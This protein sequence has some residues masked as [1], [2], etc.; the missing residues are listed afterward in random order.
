MSTATWLEVG[1]VADQRSSAHGER[2]NRLLELLEVELVPVSTQHARVAREAY[3]RY[4]R[5]SDSAARLNYGD[6]FSYALAT[7]TGEHL[8]FKGDDFTHTDVAPALQR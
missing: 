1:I 4:G 3:R 6:C 5:G 8:L 7:V 2:L